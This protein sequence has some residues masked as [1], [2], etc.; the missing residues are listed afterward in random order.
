MGAKRK[1]WLWS[2]RS[3]Q[4]KTAQGINFSA[5][6]T[7]PSSPLAVAIAILWSVLRITRR[8]LPSEGDGAP[9]PSQAKVTK[10]LHVD[11]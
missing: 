10:M 11:P 5:G 7:C 4:L 2:G 8:H 6:V 3:W 1:G 9:E